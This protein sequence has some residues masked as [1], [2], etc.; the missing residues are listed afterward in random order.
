MTHLWRRPSEPLL[1]GA[2]DSQVPMV[3]PSAAAAVTRS[4]RK[5]ALRTRAPRSRYTDLAVSTSRLAVVLMPS[6][7]RRQK[8]FHASWMVVWLFAGAGLIA[9]ASPAIVSA[10]PPS[11]VASTPIC[12]E[13]PNRSLEFWLSQAT[14]AAVIRCT[15]AAAATVHLTRVVSVVQSVPSSRKIAVGSR[16]QRE[17]LSWCTCYARGTPTLPDSKRPGVLAM[18]SPSRRMDIPFS[19]HD[20]ARGDPRRAARERPRRPAEACRCCDHQPAHPGDAG[21][22]TSRCVGHWCLHHTLV[23]SGGALGRTGGRGTGGALSRSN[24]ESVPGAA[25]SFTTAATATATSGATVETLSPPQQP[26]WSQR[27]CGFHQPPGSAGLAH[28]S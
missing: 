25:T 12:L 6:A 19:A 1:P 28:V 3:P 18:R 17:S 7:G 9:P 8:I 27:V 21:R 5:D 20:V 13:Q 15:V 24:A 26:A 23:G 10:T 2:V 4:A 16:R 11:G 14:A 22:C